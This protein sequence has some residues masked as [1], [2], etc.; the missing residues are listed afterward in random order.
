MTI[1]RRRGL[2]HALALVAGSAVEPAMRAGQGI[3]RLPVVVEAPQR[4]AV[5]VVAARTLR[6]EPPRVM[7]VLVAGGTVARRL[8]VRRAAVAF[9][10]RYRGMQ[11][12]QGKARKVMIEGDLGAPAAVLVAP[13]AFLPELAFVRVILLVAGDAR[14]LELLSVEIARVTLV[15]LGFGMLA[16]ER[17]LRL[18]VI[19]VD[20]G[21]LLRRVAALAFR[22]KACLVDILHAVARDACRR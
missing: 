9:L 5:G 8:L 19:E 18:V 1:R 17:E 20:V 2:G 6:A 22:A 4:P 3:F 13:L 14:R 16:M 11:T 15:A 21:P 7:C 10:A 12:K